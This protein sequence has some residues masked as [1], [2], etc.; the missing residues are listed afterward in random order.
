[1]AKGFALSAAS[2]F[3]CLLPYQLRCESPLPV[4]V[5]ELTANPAKYDGRLV[6]FRGQAEGAWFETSH[7]G[8]VACKGH[9][10]E[11]TRGLENADKKSM[12]QLREAVIRANPM[13]TRTSLAVVLV[14][15][16]GLFSHR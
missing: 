1:M 13:T 15:I 14:T 16:I 4:T 11:F 8:D 6:R 3:L 5:C 9:A 7:L 2:L 10:V 12:D